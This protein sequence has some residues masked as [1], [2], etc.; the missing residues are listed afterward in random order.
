MLQ[1]SLGTNIQGYY[2]A[3]RFVTGSV[4]TP[5][6]NSNFVSFLTQLIATQDWKKTATNLYTWTKLL[7]HYFCLP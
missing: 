2:N 5:I 6:R 7:R 4:F 1:S 3:D